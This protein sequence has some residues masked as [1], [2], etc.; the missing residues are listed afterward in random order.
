MN[1]RVEALEAID[2]EHSNKALLDTYTQTEANLADA[3]AKKHEHTNKTVLDGVTAEKVSA[4]DAAEGNAKTYADGLNTSMTT[5]VN[6]I[7]ARVTA[8]EGAI[9]TKAAQAD[10]TAVG[11]RVTAIETW[12]A[13]FVEVSEEEINALFATPTV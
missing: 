5:K 13:N 6:A 8:N 3:V 7:D 1:T 9:A 4:W 11:N 12:H 2:H 10:L